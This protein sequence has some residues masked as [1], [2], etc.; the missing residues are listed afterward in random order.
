MF[1]SILIIINALAPNQKSALWRLQVLV[2]LMAIFEMIG[3]AA[4]MPLITLLNDIT[5][6]EQDGIFANAYEYLNFSSHQNFIL[7]CS[8][9]VISLLIISSLLSMYTIWRLSVFATRVGAELS[10]AL[11]SYYLNQTWLYHL[12]VSNAD[13]L[14]K[15][16]FETD[17]VTEGILMHAVKINAKGFFALIVMVSLVLLSPRVAF[18]T[19]TIFGFSY[20]MLYVFVR[21]RLHRNGT[22]ISQL[23]ADRFRLMNQ[24]FGGIKEVL[25]YG[26]A[27]SFE[28]KFAQASDQY[29]ECQATNSIL[30]QV[31]RYVIELVAFGGIILTLIYLFFQFNGSLVDALPLLS[32]YALAGLK[33]LPALQNIY[34]SV[35]TIKSNLPA[36]ASISEDLEKSVFINAADN[37]PEKNE[38]LFEVSGTGIEFENVSFGYS[39]NGSSVIKN[40]SLKIPWRSRVG[41]V[42]A[43]G[44]GKSTFIDIMLGLLEVQSGRILVNGRPLKGPVLRAWQNR[45][46]FVPQ[47]IY[48]SDA[49]LLENIAFG[50]DEDQVDLEQIDR[51]LALAHLQDFVAGLEDGVHTNVGE[52]G[53]KLSGGQRQRIGIARALYGDPE[54][55]VFDEATSSLDGL[56]ER[57]VIEAIED[58]SKRK[59]I[60]IVAHR[61][62]TVVQ[63]DQIHLVEKGA[64]K[65]SGSFDSLMKSS[66]VFRKMVENS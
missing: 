9:L 26:R 10:K 50:I 4:I 54:V 6:L 7:F 51:V 27:K 49:S 58:L 1:R 16:S 64:I 31:P 59:T 15:V 32:V 11:Y 29:A 23:L 65:S 13:L 42:G 2:I 17:R 40:M 44:A 66:S 20:I 62:N 57:K 12:S 22:I 14:K 25:L 34:Q 61:L 47:T 21:V 41:F 39:L 45:I 36:F 33:L 19:A 37:S 63:C 38:N 52:R 53:V 48:L 46:G 55:L 30:S 56:T 35:A 3:I 18:A 24:G 28:R 5:I 60:I 8:L 43:S